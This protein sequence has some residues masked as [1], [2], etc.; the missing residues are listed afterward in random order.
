MACC[1]WQTFEDSFLHAW[2]R[3]NAGEALIDWALAKRY[4]RRHH[5]T[6]AEAA[7]MQLQALAEE[8]LYLWLEKFKPKK[9]NDDDDD[10]GITVCRE[11]V[12]S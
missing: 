7:S 6:G 11:P 2:R 4:W 5:S 1:D 10:G 3:K 12:F 8:G 9:G